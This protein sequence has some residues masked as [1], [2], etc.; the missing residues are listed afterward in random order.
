MTQPRFH[1][2]YVTAHILSELEAKQ[3]N[4]LTIHFPVLASS[5]RLLGCYRQRISAWMDGF[6]PVR[7]TQLS[8]NGVQL[9]GFLIAKMTCCFQGEQNSN[10]D[11]RGDRRV[12]KGTWICIPDPR[13][14]QDWR[15]DSSG[16]TG[17]AYS[18]LCLLIMFSALLCFDSSLVCQCLG[19]SS[20]LDPRCNTYLL[21]IIRLFVT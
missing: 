5:P 1:L 14:H 15:K 3:A 6:C 8:L 13:P 9:A 18:P 7:E 16:G 21:C 12:R 11:Q 20:S 19:Y 2:F 4:L 10:G 17:R